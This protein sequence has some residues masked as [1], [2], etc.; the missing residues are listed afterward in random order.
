MND[1]ILPKKI[2]IRET[3]PRE[4]WQKYKMF[5]P[6]EKKIAL[7]KRMVDSGAKDIEIGI[8]STSP[9]LSWQ[10]EDLNKVCEEMLNYTKGADVIFSGQV[11]DFN[12]ARMAQDAGLTHVHY[13]VSAS[14]S[15]SMEIA[16][17][18]I[19]HSLE[20]LER[21]MT[22]G[23]N[24]D[25]GFGA[26][27]ACPFGE[28]ITDEKLLYLIG[29]ITDLG[30]R[31]YSLAD[32]GG[33]AAPDRIRHVLRVI[34]EKY[35]SVENVGVHLHQ[36]RGMGLANAFAAME[37]GVSKLDAALGAMGGCPFIKGAKGNIATE[38]LINMAQSMGIECDQNLDETIEA[39]L[40][41]SALIDAP[42][43]SSMAGIR[44]AQQEGS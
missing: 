19:E 1:I 3:C 28:I 41:Q 27:F 30:I 8:F 26:A 31:E 21:A 37:E 6:T 43:I 15:F 10:F 39:S 12:T 36:T 7:I 5:I 9:K 44:Q 25:I 38:D 35:G 16:N 14:E 32:S 22:L 33:I 23:M 20:E 34:R 13:F 17:Q 2:S 42:I 18:P 4:G 24:I 40:Y 29:R 11:E